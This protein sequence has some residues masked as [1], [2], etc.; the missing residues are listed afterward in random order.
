VIAVLLAASVAASPAPSPAPAGAVVARVGDRV[1]T[2]AELEAAAARKLI[3][4]E[5][6][7]HGVKLQALR[8]LVDAELLRQEAAR[9]GVTVEALVR[10]EIEAKAIPVKAWDVAAYRATNAKALEGKTDAEADEEAARRLRQD[11]ISQRRFGF[12]AGLR[13]RTPASIALPPPRLQVATEG[14]ASRGPDNAPVTIVE[15]S[16]FQCP[17]CRRVLPTL[18]EVE[19]RYRG[20]VRLVFRH[21]PLA[22]HKE[23]P[24]AAEAAECARD[25][26]RFWEMH[27]RLF[28]NAERLKPAD[29]KGHA[30]AI[31]IDGAAF[32]ACLDSG[33]HAERWK[34]DLAE[35]ESYGASGTPMFFVNGRLISGAQPFAVFARV[36]DEELRGKTGGGGGTQP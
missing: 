13:A 32:D 2:E 4:V 36:I 19:E 23:A 9:R 11:R 31:G 34:R 25:Q 24:R 6:R 20:R 26:G 27:D 33:R 16:E 5:T 14:A 30:R 28:A 3:E 18:R 1:I 8:D 29:L 22:R 12:L 17:F 35:A 15:F 7:A 10:D 21:F